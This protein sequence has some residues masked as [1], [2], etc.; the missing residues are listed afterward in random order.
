M[1][2]L[3]KQIPFTMSYIGDILVASGGLFE[4]HKSI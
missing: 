1:E 2:S 4:E 3:V